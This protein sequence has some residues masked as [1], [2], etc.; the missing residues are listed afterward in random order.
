MIRC[1]LAIL[2][3]ERRLRITTVA[4]DTGISR[5]TLTALAGNTSQGIQL[6]TLNKLCLYLKVTPNHL[7]SVVPFDVR[8]IPEDIE[9]GRFYIEVRF[10]DGES[11][12]RA[13]LFANTEIFAD[14]F[15]DE[16]TE[17]TFERITDIEIDIQIPDPSEEGINEFCISAEQDNIVLMKHFCGLPISFRPDI[18]TILSNLILDM[19][20]FAEYLPKLPHLRKVKSKVKWPDVFFRES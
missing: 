13:S 16:I 6:G 11:A 3:A 2:L 18:E 17:A 12:S 15:V 4:A 1:N 19:P 5:T 9:D 7:F 10:T 8:F 14:T 20:R